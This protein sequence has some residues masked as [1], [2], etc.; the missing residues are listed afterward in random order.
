M[1]TITER[2]AEATLNKVFRYTEGIMTRKEW[3]KLKIAAGCKP[4]EVQRR[5]YAAE[6]KLQQWID[7]NKWRIPWGNNSHP[8]T[9]HWLSEKKRLQDGIYKTEYRLNDNNSNC[10]SVITKIEY[11]Y[12]QNL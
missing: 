3:L 10:F 4:E 6:E 5:N 9:K 8:D 7:S 12:I 1:K 11:D 2:R